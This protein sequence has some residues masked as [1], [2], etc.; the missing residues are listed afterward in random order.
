MQVKWSLREMWMDTSQSFWTILCL[1]STYRSDTKLHIKICR[2]LSLRLLWSVIKGVTFPWKLCGVNLR[3]VKMS[4]IGWFQFA[5]SLFTDRSV[6]HIHVECHLNSCTPTVPPEFG[7]PS[8]MHFSTA[9][10]EIAM[11]DH[12]VFRSPVCVY[13]HKRTRA[14]V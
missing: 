9:R 13:T 1:Q 3:T 12:N 11:A 6:L 8:Y 2:I 4:C 5:D 7:D 14:Y 10:L